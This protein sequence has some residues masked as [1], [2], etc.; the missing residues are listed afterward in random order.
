MF[1]NESREAADS[2][3]PSPMALLLPGFWT[4]SFWFW[5]EYQLGITSLQVFPRHRDG[6]FVL[7]TA[8]WR[9]ILNHQSFHCILFSPSVGLYQD[10]SMGRDPVPGAQEASRCTLVG[11]GQGSR[12]LTPP[13]VLVIILW[14]PVFPTACTV[15]WA[16]DFGRLSPP[17]LGSLC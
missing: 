12:Q 15:P 14:N 7:K 2:P 11:C 13:D 6:F 10:G 3:I 17:W 8:T 1:L 4:Y 16:P 5:I 9:L